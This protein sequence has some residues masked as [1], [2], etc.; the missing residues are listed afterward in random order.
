M[1]LLWENIA[2]GRMRSITFA[3]APRL[4]RR[5]VYKH[6]ILGGVDCSCRGMD[7]VRCSDGLQMLFEPLGISE[8][9]EQTAL[10]VMMND[11]TFLSARSSSEDDASPV[12]HNGGRMGSAGIKDRGGGLS[13]ATL[14]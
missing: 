5:A 14:G 8:L 3:S 13:A 10:I 11:T 7:H 4:Q 2:L 6:P 1:N 9:V 12:A